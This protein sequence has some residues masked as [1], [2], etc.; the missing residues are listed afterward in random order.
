MASRHI[1]TPH[2]QDISF[3][4]NDLH[5]HLLKFQGS[6]QENKRFSLYDLG[7]LEDLYCASYA[8]LEGYLQQAT[9][10]LSNGFRM[11]D[12]PFF[13]FL[14]TPLADNG[15][16]TLG[17]FEAL[18]LTQ[19]HILLSEPLMCLLDRVLDGKYNLDQPQRQGLARRIWCNT[20][21]DEAEDHG[22]IDT[23]RP[24]IQ[25]LRNL[26]GITQM[27]SG[28][29]FGQ[30]SEKYR[31]RTPS[32]GT[33][34]TQDTPQETSIQPTP[35]IS[36]YNLDERFKKL[37]D[38]NRADRPCICDP[39]CI[40]APLCA[41]DP[42]QNC[43]CEENALFVSVT[44][45]MDIDDLDVPDLVR[46]ERL[47]SNSGSESGISLISKDTHSYEAVGCTPTPPS[48]NE[49]QT[50]TQMSTHKFDQVARVEEDFNFARSRMPN[51]RTPPLH[52]R[53]ATRSMT[54]SLVTLQAGNNQLTTIPLREALTLPFSKQCDTPPQRPST[55]A[56]MA[57]RLFRGRKSKS[58]VA[59]Q[60]SSPTFMPAGSFRIIKRRSQEHL[61]LPDLRHLGRLSEFPPW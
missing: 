1:L 52:E 47:S 32:F 28:M 57:R 39:E 20:N 13:T 55:R 5:F 58:T 35:Y 48:V 33:G 34:G 14:C 22:D 6:I 53:A 41:S 38:P 50:S 23:E 19:R 26:S 4:P 61:V 59:N 18:L 31:Q 60:P 44:E 25:Q 54:G 46:K 37:M 10:L 40:C 45:G 15:P 2:F 29:I 12:E 3:D 30:L 56:A 43:L 21:A 51:A 7:R 8:K 16:V 17:D 49:L 11:P 36:P 9:I 27:S 24:W 42:T